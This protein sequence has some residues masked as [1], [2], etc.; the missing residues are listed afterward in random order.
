MQLFLK[1]FSGMVNSVDP[2]QTAPWSSLIWICTVGICHFVRNFD[3]QNFRT[4]TVYCKHAAL[5]G[6]STELTGITLVKW[7]Q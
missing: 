5:L 4:F 1:M 6:S 2:N 7:F 3:V